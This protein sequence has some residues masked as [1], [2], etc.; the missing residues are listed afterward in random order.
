MRRTI[1]RNGK[2][3]RV[4][5]RETTLKPSG[6]VRAGRQV[7]VA[8]RLTSADG[9]PVPGAEV[10]VL[11]RTAPGAAEQPEALLHTDADGR[12][13]YA[14]PGSASRTLRLLYAGAPR[15]L[16]AQAEIQLHVAAASSLRVSRRAVRNQQAVTFLGRV[17][18]LPLPATGKLV[19]LQVRLSHR[20]ETFRTTRTDATGRW[21]IRYRFKRAYRGVQRF[22]FR[23]HLPREAGYPFDPGSSHRVRVRVTGHR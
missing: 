9:Q 8:G 5:R 22:R 6:H 18:T 13:S 20:W 7:T 15:I 1:R 14:A 4:R 2:R 16:P 10:Q 12:L 11:A 21:S 23:A 3:H 17:R 19:E